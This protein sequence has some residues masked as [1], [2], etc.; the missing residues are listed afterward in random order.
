MVSTIFRKMA[1]IYNYQVG[2]WQRQFLQEL[3]RAVF[4]LRGRVNFT[5]L[6]RFSPLHEQTFRRHFQKAFRWVWFNLTIFRLRRHPEEPIIGVFDCSFLP[7]SGT[8][9]WGLDQFFSSL[10]GRSKR[11]MEVSV[12]GIV[13][14]GSS[15]AFGVD[16]TQTPPDLSTDQE[17]QYSRVDFYLE[18]IIDLYD[19]LANLG[20]SYSVG[21][22][23]YAKQKVFD[24]VTGLGGDL[25]T[26]LRSD[27][28]LRYLY[29][30]PPKDGPGRPRQYDGKVDWDDHKA[31]TRRF[32]EVGR[33]PDQPQVRILTTV[34]NSPHFGRDFRVVLLVGPDGEKQVILASTDTSQPAEEV[35]RYYRLRYQIEF[36]I[37]DAK[38]HAGLTHCQ[39]RSQEKLDF[40]LNMSVAA[41]N[42]LRL[43]AQKAECS[44]RTY[45]REAYNR[46]LISQLFSKL[47]LSAEYDRTDPRV[48]SVV[49]TGRMAV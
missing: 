16:A 46:L 2:F 26:R 4:S 12:L 8:E 23:F 17:G 11:G 25:I 33:L 36:V 49:R 5:N 18:Q 44:L 7:K 30:G 37:R 29:T 32:D 47:G 34:A 10:A 21:D 9:T 31:L 20:V 3:F 19:Q 22:G 1:D 14:T 27:A 6:A 24:T 48:Q 45:R 28:N 42:L 13:A 41:V 43:L 35:A 38:Q 15:R 40:H 39:A